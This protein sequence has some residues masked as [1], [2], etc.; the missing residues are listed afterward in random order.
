MVMVAVCDDEKE[1][2][3]EL[4]QALIAIFGNLAV[5][6]EID[7]FFSA[8]DLCR[9][10]EAGARYDLLF[11]DIEFAKDEINGVEAGRLIREA[12]HN[13]L[14][15]IVYISWQIRYAMEL[16]EIRPM[17]FLT[18]PLL[19]E[20][21]EQTVKTHLTISGISC[22][23]FTWQKGRDTLKAQVK[24]IIYLENHERKIT[25][26]FS[27]GRR[28]DFYGTLKEVYNEQ[29]KNFD[30]LYIHA[31]FLVNYD[32]VTVAKY[33]HMLVKGSLVPLPISQ[34]RRVE[35]REQYASIMKRRR[36]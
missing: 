22:G 26:Y 4:E 11:L 16:F 27:D 18:K 34:N 29:L 24:D 35:I 20:K 3:A 13:N 30:F 8:E 21:I 19:Y 28:D 25:I 5:M 32:Y 31:S 10:L 36:V 1:I 17:N 6:H 14:I 7:L 2:A 9:K 23:V 33:D 12:Q 15:S